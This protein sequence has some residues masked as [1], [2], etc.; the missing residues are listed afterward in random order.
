[1]PLPTEI[2]VAPD[3]THKTLSREE[4]LSLMLAG[5]RQ[6]PVG[7]W[8]EHPD[9][10]PGLTVVTNLLKGT[11]LP[12]VRIAL[13][14]TDDWTAI[15]AYLRWGGWNEC[16]APEYQVA[17]FR[18]WRDRYGIELVGMTSDTLNLTVARPPS[19]RE[20]AL[21]LAREQYVYCS[22][23][24]DQ[25]TQTLSALAATLMSGGWWFFWWD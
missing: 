9:E 19:T 14:P 6:P 1:M 25:G 8:P 17:A 5:P 22:D 21:A 15:P 12:K 10:A 16:P 20:E 3:G 11:A 13:I 24:V 2:V 18:Y 23:I 7:D 4:T